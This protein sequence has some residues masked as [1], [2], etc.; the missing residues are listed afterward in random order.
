MKV[1]IV[2]L[3]LDRYE[4]DVIEHLVVDGVVTI[5]EARDCRCIRE[6]GDV[7][8]LMWVRRIQKVIHTFE[9]KAS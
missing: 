4:M 8:S 7:G 1:V 3:D 9:K 6:L 2:R 5:Q